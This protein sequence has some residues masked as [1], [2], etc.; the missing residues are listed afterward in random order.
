MWRARR[1]K[2][3]GGE[4]AGVLVVVHRGA[5]VFASGDSLITRPHLSASVRL[6]GTQR[7]MSVPGAPYARRG[8]AR[9]TRA[10]SHASAACERSDVTKQRAALKGAKM[11]WCCGGQGEQQPP[12]RSTP[13]EVTEVHLA[14]TFS[15]PSIAY[16][17][18][19]WAFE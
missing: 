12:P 10:G 6:P 2:N 4:G 16:A 14:E 7:G 11:S 1:R 9:Q 18:S 13:K 17:A 19:V 8:P 5:V 15:S 3:G